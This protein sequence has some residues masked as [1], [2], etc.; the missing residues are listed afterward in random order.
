MLN[1]AEEAMLNYLNDKYT[2]YLNDSE[3]QNII[4]ELSGTY[5]GIGVSLKGREI[6][7]VTQSSPAEK[8]GIL[9]GD[10]ILKVNEHNISEMN[11]SDEEVGTTIRNIIRDEKVK[12]VNLE[13]DRAGLTLSFTISKENLVDPSISSR[14]IEGTTTGYI[15]IKNFSQNL[16]KQISKALGELESQNITS[17]IIDVRDN[18]GGYLASAEEVASLFLEEGKIIYSLESSAN[19]VTYRDKTGEKRNYKIAVLINGN[20]ASASE[21]LAAALKESYGATLVGTKSYG[22]GKVQ[23]VMSLSNGDSM[24]YTSAKWLTPTGNCIDG[25]GLVP[26]VSVAYEENS[27]ED[28]QIRKAVE[29][30]Q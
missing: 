3:Y 15:Y 16:S 23:Q 11:A 14:V 21:V 7:E 18:V 28:V 9:A 5:N 10:K 8:A 25:V 26:D 20:S 13:I 24:K 17:L 30:L 22:K 1:A 12:V 29:I 19:T 27:A 4:D 2:T 6:I